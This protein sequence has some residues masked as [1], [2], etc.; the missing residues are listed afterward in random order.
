MA[1][2]LIELLGIDWKLE[3]WHDTFQEKAAEL[4]KAKQAGD[5]IE[6]AAPPKSTNVIEL[7]EALQ[8]SVERARGPK[9]GGKGGGHQCPL[10]L[11][12]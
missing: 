1:R 6:R 11:A 9:A 8:A 12:S 7:V 2:Q 4:L 5:S 10:W 3:E